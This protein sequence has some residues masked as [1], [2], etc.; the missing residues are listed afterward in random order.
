MLAAMATK[1]MGSGG[2]KSGPGKGFGKLAQ[3]FPDMWWAWGTVRMGPGIVFPRNMVIVREANG[4]LVV[5][6]PVM[7]PPDEQAKVEALGPIKHVV[8]LGAFHGMDDPAY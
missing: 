3:V 1:K 7:M 8:R 2:F 4:D 6:H 5:I